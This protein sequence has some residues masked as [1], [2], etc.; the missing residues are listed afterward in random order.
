MITCLFYSWGDICQFLL[1][2][3]EA[4]GGRKG[5]CYIKYFHLLFSGQTI[6][7]C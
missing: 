6:V 2:L 4:S 3:K 5:E 7:N 1:M